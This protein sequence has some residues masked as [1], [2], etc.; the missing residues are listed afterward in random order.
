VS[1]IQSHRDLIVWQ[2]RWSFLFGLRAGTEVPGQ[3]E[4]SPTSQLTRAA[5]SVPANIAEGHARSTARDFAN[6]LAIAR[7]SLAETETYVLLAVRLGYLLQEQAD[8]TLDLVNE[9]GRMLSALRRR[10]SVK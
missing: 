7:G 8:D 2:R 10:I 5:V 4:L 1:G 9:V 3:R 6:F